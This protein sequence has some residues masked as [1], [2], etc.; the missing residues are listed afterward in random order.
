VFVFGV[1]LDFR[2]GS[3]RLDRLDA[4]LG[5]GLRLVPLAARDGLPIG[6]F[7]VEPEIS[8]LLLKI[9]N[10]AA[11]RRSFDRGGCRTR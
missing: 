7:E 11:I 8:G 9:S 1:V 4:L 2:G 10:F 6:R 3:V 5:C